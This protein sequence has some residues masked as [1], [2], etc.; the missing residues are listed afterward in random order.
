[1]RCKFIDCC[2]WE[3]SFLEDCYCKA[4]AREKNLWY[5]VDQEC[6]ICAC[7]LYGRQLNEKRLILGNHLYQ[8]EVKPYLEGE[9]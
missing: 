2:H 6:F 5:V 7:P 8:K 9:I 3:L 4:A 1:M